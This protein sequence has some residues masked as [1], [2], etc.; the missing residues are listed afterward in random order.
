[1]L[2]Q[3]NVQKFVTSVKDDQLNQS[4]ESSLLD[5]MGKHLHD[6]SLYALDICSEML[7]TPDDTLQVSVEANVQDKVPRKKAVLHHKASVY[8]L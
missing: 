8:D 1:M 3:F 7:L 2:G 6:K 5:T 4:N